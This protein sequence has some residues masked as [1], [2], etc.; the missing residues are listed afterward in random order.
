MDPRLTLLVLFLVTGVLTDTPN[1]SSFEKF[2]D[3]VVKGV[4]K[5]KHDL[6]EPYHIEDLEITL[7]AQIR[8]H[9]LPPKI[10]IH[11]SNNTLRGITTIHRS[12]H[13]SV[14]M[15]G[16][17]RWTKVQ[18]AAGPLRETS[19]LTISILGLRLRPTVEINISNLDFTI[20]ILGVKSSELLKTTLFK[21][22]ELKGL[23]VTLKQWKW[24]DNIENRIINR[25][26]PLLEDKIRTEVEDTVR[27]HLD[28]KLQSLPEELKKLLYG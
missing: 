13:A 21:I 3:A 12:G 2:L 26:I 18:M 19:C 15:E 22:N 10:H 25:I 6:I 20:E 16:G 4:I 14:K 9:K 8:A 11:A 24:T 17:S 27:G 7:Q 23:K 5:K 28:D 1:D